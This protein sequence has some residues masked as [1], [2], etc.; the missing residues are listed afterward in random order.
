[1]RQLLNA[2]FFGLKILLSISFLTL[3]AKD[4]VITLDRKRLYDIVNVQEGDIFVPL[5]YLEK[6]MH[7]HVSVSKINH[8]FELDADSLQKGYRACFGA[9]L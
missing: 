7:N 6:I 9:K 2:D 8:T 4:I 3:G 5:P 1:M